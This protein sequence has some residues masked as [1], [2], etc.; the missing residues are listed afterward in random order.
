MGIEPYIKESEALAEGIIIME[1][2]VYRV[3]R[4]KIGSQVELT[5]REF[6]ARKVIAKSLEE[7][8]EALLDIICERFG[9]GEPVLDYFDDSSI[10]TPSEL[11]CFRSNE[12][13]LTTNFSELYADGRCSSCGAGLGA[14][15]VDAIRRVDKKLKTDVAFTVSGPSLTLLFSER[16]ILLLI[17]FGIP[18]ELVAPVADAEGKKFAE[19]LPSGKIDWAPAKK[20]RA[21]RVGAQKCRKCGFYSFSFVDLMQKDMRRFIAETDLGLVADNANIVGLV[22]PEPVLK[23]FAREH[24]RADEKIKGFVWG[25]VGSVGRD[26]LDTKLKYDAFPLL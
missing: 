16:L 25:R 2:Q 7:A 14:R 11:W 19:F 4:A 6:P 15:R 22:E 18:S 21:V 20:H 5:L 3:T 12:K 8:E 10:R 17:E 23:P 13:T 1:N 9:D 26:D 24:I